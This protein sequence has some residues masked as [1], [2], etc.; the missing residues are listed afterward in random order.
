MKNRLALLVLLVACL[1]VTGDTDAQIQLGSGLG[2]N[3]PFPI[4]LSGSVPLSGSSPVTLTLAQYRNT[5]LRFTGTTSATI[6]ITAPLVQG[7]KFD[8]TNA[9]NNPITFGGATGTSVTIAP[10]PI[11]VAVESEDGANYV[12]ANPAP[13]LS[14]TLFVDGG[15]TGGLAN[16]SSAAPYKT[17]SA[18]LATFGQ[19]VSTAD[20]NSISQAWISSASGGYT[21]EPS[22]TVVIPAYRNTVLQAMTDTNAI[23]IVSSI[24][25][26][27]GANV[28]WVNTAAA[29]G[30]FPPTQFSSLIISKLT[31][32]GNLTVTDD[33]TSNESLFITSN[34]ILNGTVSF[35]SSTATREIDIFDGSQ[36]LGTLDVAGS[37]PSIVRVY[38]SLLY[39][40]VT[41]QDV[42]VSG[43]STV[44]GSVDATV[45]FSI[46]ATGP[47]TSG[48]AVIDSATYTV[49]N[50]FT[51]TDVTIIGST[52][53]SDAAVLTQVNFQG[54]T[55]DCGGATLQNDTFSG[56]F[57]LTASTVTT[58]AQSWGNYLAQGGLLN[59]ATVSIVSAA[60][61]P[62]TPSNWSPAP[63]TVSGALDQLAAR[64]AG[65]GGGGSGDGGACSCTELTNTAVQTGPVSFTAPANSFVPVDARAGRATISLPASPSDNTRVAV[66]DV[67]GAFSSGAP[68]SPCLVKTTDGS[69]IWTG[70]AYATSTS[71]F[72]S[73]G[74]TYFRYVASLN[75]WVQA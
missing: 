69:M 59:G 13:S 50:T 30:D 35:A 46:G 73:G 5:S 66:S 64:D 58:D 4:L 38:D 40:T 26:S 22:G 47:S 25:P 75:Y 1:F 11:P 65:G 39:A 27:I 54:G 41:I 67:Y 60:Y 6:A 62:A 72:G 17:V 48:G 12:Q 28:T 71:L 44:S 70:A 55:L 19:P 57:Q 29:G 52:G 74:T 37:G 10:I 42:L 20:A 14:R 68:A 63:T 61:K 45:A 7:M 16:G 31:L 53:S 33:A 36:I 49:G 56:G 8:V 9:T 34:G 43:A 24:G 2:P 3:G 23:S 51:A 15:F 21:S 18:A 32:T